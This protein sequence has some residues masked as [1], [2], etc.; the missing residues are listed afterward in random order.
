MSRI[1]V[2]VIIFPCL[3]ILTTDMAN[4][5]TE[6]YVCPDTAKIITQTLVDPV[7]YA[8]WRHNFFKYQDAQIKGTKPQK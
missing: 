6:A 7:D 1:I 4:K 2:E 5:S 8:K 3:S